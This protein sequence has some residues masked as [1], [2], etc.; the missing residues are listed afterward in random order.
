MEEM[1]EKIMK[2][3]NDMMEKIMYK[4]I[5]KMMKMKNDMIELVRNMKEKQRYLVEKVYDELTNFKQEKEDLK[6]EIHELINQKRQVN[7]DPLIYY[8]HLKKY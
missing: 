1:M 5:K 7:S 6:R 8:Q 3:N 4:M 2:M